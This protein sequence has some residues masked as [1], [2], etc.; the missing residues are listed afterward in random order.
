MH[1]QS[2]GVKSKFNGVS[3]DDY[4]DLPE[5]PKNLESFEIDPNVFNNLISSVGYSA[6]LDDNRPI[7]TGIFLSYDG[8]ELTAAASDG[9]RLSEAKVDLKSDAS[10]FTVVIPAKTLLDVAR[11]YVE[12]ESPITISLDEN[13]NL[14]LFKQDETVIATRIIDGEYPDYNRIIPQENNI[15]AKFNVPQL[16][17][18]VKLTDIFAKEADGAIVMKIDPKGKFVISAT[19]QD[20]GEHKSDVKVEVTADEPAEIGF[21]SKFLL[22]F[23][24]NVKSEEINLQTN[25]SAS[26]CVF[27]PEGLDAYIHIIMPMQITG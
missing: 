23:L 22:D 10:K 26:P 9:F 25:G 24:N 20:T 14:V 17:E 11:V 19:A 21:S 27:R 2:E 1:L 12:S 16:L 6:A 13:E 15:S 7:F 18:A 8:K 5:E 3:A 4:P